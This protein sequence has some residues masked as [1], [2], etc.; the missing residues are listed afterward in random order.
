MT[1]HLRCVDPLGREVLLT[2]ERWFDH[3]VARHDEFRGREFLVREALTA[4]D[5]VNRDRR[6]PMRELFYRVSPLPEPYTDLL[7]RVV[8]KF[9]AAGEVVTA[10]FI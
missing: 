3:I 5:F 10:H 4:P 2:R 1:D 8:V 7:V 9:Y 6:R